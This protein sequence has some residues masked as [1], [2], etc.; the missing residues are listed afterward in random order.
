MQR[1]P[2]GYDVQSISLIRVA[3]QAASHLACCQC[4]LDS[5]TV[6]R[7]AVPSVA[8][9]PIL[10]LLYKA[11]CHGLPDLSALTKKALETMGLLPCQIIH[12]GPGNGG[13]LQCRS[14]GYTGAISCVRNAIVYQVVDRILGEWQV[15]VKEM[16]QDLLLSSAS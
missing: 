11:G 7:A 15:A 4:L 10:T 6:V 1:L 5:E 13:K 16:R 8:C 12:L 2:A 14:W 9:A 3:R